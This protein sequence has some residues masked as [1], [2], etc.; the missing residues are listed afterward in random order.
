MHVIQ[1]SKGQSQQIY[2]DLNIKNLELQSQLFRID[3]ILSRLEISEQYLANKIVYAVKNKLPIALIYAKELQ[4]VRSLSTKISY[5][6]LQ[7][8]RLLRPMIDGQKHVWR[9]N[10]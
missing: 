8:K 3:L 4:K 5:M 9:Q 10:S 2:P 1:Q 7:M 6:N